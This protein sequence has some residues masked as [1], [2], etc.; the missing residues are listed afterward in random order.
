M[1][2][3]LTK[4]WPVGISANPK[5]GIRFLVK[6]PPQN[7]H[8]VIDVLPFD[9]IVVQLKVVDDLGLSEFFNIVRVTEESLKDFYMII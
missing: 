9:L 1:A 2:A 8:R 7:H 5:F 3:L 4:D 6:A